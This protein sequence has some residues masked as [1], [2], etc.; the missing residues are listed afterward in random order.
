MDFYTEEYIGDLYKLLEPCK[1]VIGHEEYHPEGSVWIHSF[2]VLQLALRETDDTDLILAALMHDVGKQC[3][4]L[5]HDHEAMALL[6][7]YFSTKGLWLVKEHMRVWSMLKGEM[8]RPGKVR[9]LLTHPWLPELIGLAR[10][11]SMGRVKNKEFEISVERLTFE[12]NKKVELHFKAKEPCSNPK[13][14]SHICSPW[15]C[16]AKE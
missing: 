6:A 8:K 15:T 5:G 2:Q 7:P 14:G 4:K 9:E 3:E 12:L 1:E 11:D 13:Y 10:W 16:G